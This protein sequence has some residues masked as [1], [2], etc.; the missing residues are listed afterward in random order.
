MGSPLLLCSRQPQILSIKHAFVP[1]TPASSLVPPEMQRDVCYR[2]RGTDSIHTTTQQ[3]SLYLNYGLSKSLSMFIFLLLALG[4]VHGKLIS[5]SHPFIKRCFVQASLS[6]SLMVSFPLGS[7][8][9]RLY[10]S[11]WWE[12]Y[13]LN[14]GGLSSGHGSYS[15][16]DDLLHH[17]NFLREKT[18][19]A[20]IKWDYMKVCFFSYTFGTFTFHVWAG[21]WL[22]TEKLC[23]FLVTCAFC[24]ALNPISHSFPA[25]DLGQ[26]D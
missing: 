11:A 7:V 24:A 12:G 1:L 21:V 15:I 19:Y 16:S 26:G 20:C 10:F 13:L 6:S 4:S 22:S 25:F 9:L 23:V 2:H 14:G 17:V 8:C 3:K 18:R 5:E